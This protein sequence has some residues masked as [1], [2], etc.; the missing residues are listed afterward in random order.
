[1]IVAAIIVSYNTTNLLRRCIRSVRDSA[2]L[3]PIIVVDNASCDGSAN[4]VREE[5][6]DV[7]LIAN[8]TNLGFAAACNQAIHSTKAPF[9]FLLNPDTIVDGLD[10]SRLIDIMRAQPNV[11]VCAP[12]IV[13]ADGSLQ[14]SCRR[15]PRLPLLAMD[16]L[17]LAK[18]FPQSQ[19]FGEYR[20]TWWTHNDLREVDQP[21]GA[22]LLLRSK[23]IDAVG[24]FDE[25]FFM[26]FEEVDLCFRLAKRGWKIIF[27]PD[28]SVTH[29]GGSSA[30]QDITAMTLARYRSMF[31]FYR[32]HYPPSHLFVLKCA[33]TLAIVG[34]V[35]A[36]SLP[37]FFYSGKRAAF[38]A[39]LRQLRSL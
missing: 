15:F 29:I 4:M 28:T 13:N 6:P 22:A 37:P 36:Y 5:F 9:Y 10:I 33:V 19:W 20:M 3:S 30:K 39:V 38:F 24:T 12:K 11:A 2:R 8:S 1:M 35:V 26:Y 23:A 14:H 34:R 27:V 7:I 21:M 16:E 25:R 18:L 17:G 31:N 32:K